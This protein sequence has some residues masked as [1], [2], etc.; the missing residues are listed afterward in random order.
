[1]SFLTP[2]L[3]V[4]N[5]TLQPIAPF[6]WFG[7]SISTLDLASTARLCLV[8]RQIREISQNQHEKHGS[9]PPVEPYSFAKHIFATL[10]VVY[11]GEAIIGTW[12]WPHDDIG[13]DS[14]YECIAPYLGMP[15]SFMVSGVVP[16][17]YITVQA[18][19]EILPAVPVP[20]LYTE[21]PLSIWDGFS[22]AML[23]CS[24]IPPAVTAN[25]STLIS[26]SAWCLLLT[27]LVRD[28]SF[29]IITRHH[30]SSSDK[31]QR[32]LFPR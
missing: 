29:M 28:A 27:S 24:L 11:G 9:K 3:E 15:P 31:R 6:T 26:S 19:I 7:L 1:M 17:L 2:F 25:S 32:R 5:Y 8:L 4:Y 20:S 21:L 23:L 14:S 12:R 13:S 22:R 16:V 30:K 10:L 18:L